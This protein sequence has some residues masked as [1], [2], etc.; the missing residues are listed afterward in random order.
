MSRIATLIFSVFISFF[1]LTQSIDFGIEVQNNYNTVENF[2]TTDPY[3]PTNLSVSVTDLAGDTSNIFLSKF[4][5]ENNFEIPLYFRFNLKKRW[6]FDFKLSNSSNTLTM[7]GVTNYNDNYYTSNFG[8]YNQ[9]VSNASL[10]GFSA[11]SVDYVN[12][13]NSAKSLNESE[14]RTV[15]KF[16]LLM[17]TVNGG[18]RLFPHKSVKMVIGAG[19]TVK[20][21][22]RKHL[23]NYLDFSNPYIE[24]IR[25]VESGLDWFAERSTYFNFMMGLELYR[26]RIA[27]YAQLGLSYT[28][29]Q[30]N[31]A[32]EVTQVADGTAFDVI[33]SYGFSMSA[34]LFSLDIGKQVKIDEVSMDDVIVSNLRKK[35]EKWDVGVQYDRRGFNDM[36]T[37]YNLP[38]LRLS[39]MTVDSVLY[40]ENGNFVKALDVELMTLGDIKRVKW[41]GRLSG[42][43]NIYLSNRFGIR[44]SIG[45]SSL[46]Y[47]I[48][49]TQLKTTILDRDTLGL[50][51]L[52][53][54]GTP[55]VRRAA[56]RKSAFVMDINADI[57][58]KIIDRDLFSFRVFAGIGISGLGYVAFNKKGNQKGINDLEVYNQFDE[59]FSSKIPV[60]KNFETYQGELYVD[61]KNPPE[62]LFDSFNQSGS[63][64]SL[65]PQDKRFIYPTIRFGFDANFDRYS[66]GF[67]VDKSV[68]G[69]DRFL[70]SDYTSIYMSVSYKIF[71]R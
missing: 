38:D 1:G 41:G 34:N 26:F 48:E 61:I 52:T 11:D 65:N 56:F 55:S 59:W 9:F 13:I 5:M 49:T 7:E 22:Y 32:S 28:F 70:L 71:R 31:L 69:M 15:E 63:E 39:V 44:G 60:E 27:A 12:Y 36:Y 18:I 68:G 24:D 29:P 53:T 16:Q 23:Y 21:K 57:S 58:Y 37:Y 17:F 30:Q 33:R 6:F 3:D 40:N 4:K 64:F 46:T 66:V 50:E 25:S 19:F 62:Y 2:F 67:G 51:F 14:V 8:T 35:R 10:Q 20:H 43:M 47:D 45:G 54:D 42:F